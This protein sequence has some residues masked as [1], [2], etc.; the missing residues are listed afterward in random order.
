MSKLIWVIS[1]IHT[2]HRE[3]KIPKKLDGIIVAGDWTTTREISENYN[4][5]V[6][7][8]KWL[9]GI[10]AK[11]KLVIPGNHD[12]SWYHYMRD[13]NPYEDIKVMDFGITWFGDTSI[14]VMSHTPT[15]GTGW[16]YNEYSDKLKQRCEAIFDEPNVLVTHGPPHGILDMTDG[17]HVGCEHLLKKVKEIK[18]DVHIFGHIHTERN[19]INSAIQ[20]RYGTLFVNASVVNLHHKVINNGKLIVI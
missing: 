10:N 2:K 9:N 19:H 7:F 11:Y 6:D 8:F 18:P 20:A 4:E 13:S 15:F 16:A 5:A 12:T 3:L 17:M 14:S 1:D